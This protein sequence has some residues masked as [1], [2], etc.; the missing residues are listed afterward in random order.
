M[1]EYQ[2]YSDRLSRRGG[3]KEVKDKITP[4]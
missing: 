3:R 1:D 2:L 4:K